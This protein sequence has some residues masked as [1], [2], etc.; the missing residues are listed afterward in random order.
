MNEKNPRY[1]IMLCDNNCLDMKRIKT[2][3]GTYLNHRIVQL[4]LD[5]LNVIIFK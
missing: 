2:L 5:K 3:K 4:A 1:S